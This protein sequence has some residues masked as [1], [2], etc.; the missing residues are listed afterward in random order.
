MKICYLVVTPKYEPK[1]NLK[2]CKSMSHPVFA[3]LLCGVYLVVLDK[4][5][6]SWNPQ[7]DLVVER[8]SGTS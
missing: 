2:Y 8:G 6:C 5:P 1:I 3:F 7:V 4:V